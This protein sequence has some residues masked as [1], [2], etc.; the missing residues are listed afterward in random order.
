MISDKKMTIFFGPI[1]LHC[2]VAA[3]SYLEDLPQTSNRLNNISKGEEGKLCYVGD[4]NDGEGVYYFAAKKDWQLIP[5]IISS[6]KEL[7]K[8]PT[9]SEYIKVETKG[10]L[11]AFISW[12]GIKYDKVKFSY[13]LTKIS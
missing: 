11:V 13:S 5:T 1:S 9:K 4:K 2:K 12:L 3:T 8:I 7:Y 10:L 6:L